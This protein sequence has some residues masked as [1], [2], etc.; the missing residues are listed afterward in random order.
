MLFVVPLYSENSNQNAVA[1]PK[2]TRDFGSG[3]RW[4]NGEHCP[5]LTFHTTTKRPLEHSKIHLLFYLT[6][7]WI[8]GN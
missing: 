6:I 5:C 3:Q 4:Q 1:Y 7:D 2:I 8:N